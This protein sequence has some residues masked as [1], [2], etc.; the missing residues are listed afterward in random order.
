VLFYEVAV[1]IH[2]KLRLFTARLN[3]YFV[4]PLAI[5]IVFPHY[6]NDLSACRFSLIVFWTASG[7]DFRSTFSLGCFPGSAA[8]PKVSPKILKRVKRRQ[9]FPSKN[10]ACQTLQIC[11][12]CVFLQE[13]LESRL[14]TAAAMKWMKWIGRSLVERAAATALPDLRR[15]CATKSP[16]S[17]SP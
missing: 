9:I 4:V 11:N 2:L 10:F 14:V 12:D 7:S 1:R 13:G 16:L 8:T 15:R 3:Q 6:L 5:W 17:S